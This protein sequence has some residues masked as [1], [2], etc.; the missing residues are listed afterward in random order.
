MA[1]SIPSL[2]GTLLSMK[3]LRSGFTKIAQPSE[4]RYL[5]SDRKMD[6]RKMQFGTPQTE[7]LGVGRFLPKKHVPALGCFRFQ[8]FHAQGWAL[9]VLFWCVGSLVALA[10][11]FQKGVEH[12]RGTFHFHSFRGSFFSGN[13]QNPRNNKFL[14]RTMVEKN[15]ESTPG[16]VFSG[17]DVH[18]TTQSFQL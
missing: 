9:I 13:H 1:L 15:G 3:H 12:S 8:P 6:K 16:I 4:R 5:C 18:F 11:R 10:I 2:P 14:K 7:V 17:L